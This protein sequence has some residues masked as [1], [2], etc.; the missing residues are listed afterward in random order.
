MESTLC[1]CD[2]GRYKVNHLAVL[3]VCKL[4]CSCRSVLLRAVTREAVELWSPQL[5]AVPPVHECQSTVLC[6]STVSSEPL[7]SPRP[8]AVKIPHVSPQICSLAFPVVVK[9]GFFLLS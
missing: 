3:A 9:C 4:T 2:Q 5:S 1:G 7:S 8:L 6:E